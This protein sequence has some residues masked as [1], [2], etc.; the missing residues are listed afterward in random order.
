MED[1]LP[2]RVCFGGFEFDLKSGELRGGGQAVRLAEKPFRVLL[3]LVEHAG[4]LVT[5]EE[6]QKSL[7]PNDTIVDFEHGINTA[8]KVL[9]RALGDPAEHPRFIETLP[10]R[11]YRLLVPV[12]R[13]AANAAPLNV[14]ARPQPPGLIGKKVS[15][16]RVLDIIG[17]GG[18]GVVYRA[19]DLKLGRAVALKFLPE[20]VANDALALQRFERE[21]RTASSLN[22]PNICTIHEVEEHDGQPFLVMELLQGET[23]RDR[24][25][26]L[27]ASAK[28]IPVEQLLDIAL[29]VAD[30]LQAAH[31]KGIIHRDI[32]PANIFL[33]TQGQIKILDFGLAKLVERPGSSQVKADPAEPPFELSSRAEAASFA[34]GVERSA[35]RDADAL[36]G[37]GFNRADEASISPMHG[38]QHSELMPAHDHEKDGHN[39]TP[40]GVP[41]QSPLD[42]TLTRTGAA[43]GTAGYMS[44]EQVRGEKLDART[45][46][47]SFGLVLYE[48]ATGRRAFSGGTAAVVRDAILSSPPAPP[49]ELNPAVPAKLEA[50]INKSLEK[51]RDRR[52]Q[53]ASEIGAAL[54][55][56]KQPTPRRSR[57]SVWAV[58]GFAVVLA[59][60]A[61]FLFLRFNSKTSAPSKNLVVRQL[62]PHSQDSVALN[63]IALSPDGKRLAYT[64]GVTGISLLQ[65]DSGETRS[66]ANTAS[67]VPVEWLP[68]GDH[69]FLTKV[70]EPGIFKMSILDG[71]VRNFSAEPIFPLTSPD[72]QQIA[73]AKNNDEIWVMSAAGDS[74]RK[75]ISIPPPWVGKH[76]AWSPTGK[77]IAY[78]K[79][80]AIQ[81]DA[82]KQPDTTMQIVIDTC[83]L[84]GNCSEAFSDPRLHLEITYSSIA[85][86]PDGRMIFSLRESPPNER[87]SN[88]WSLQVDPDSGRALGQPVRL[89]N[90]TGSAQEDMV[91]SADG[92][93]LA[94]QQVNVETAVKVAALRSDA[95]QLETGRALNSDTWSGRVTGWTPDGQT[96]TFTAVR[97]GKKGIFRQGLN[98]RTPQALVA[99]THNYDTPVLSPDGQWL[100]Y[101][102]HL[103]DGSARLM[104]MLLKGGPATEVM[105]GDYG[106]RCSSSAANICIISEMRG[107]QVVF[108]EFDPFKGR[109]RDLIAADVKRSYHGF[110][111][112][113]SLSPDGKLIALADTGSRDN[114][115]VF[116]IADGGVKT[117]HLDSW[118]LLQS[119]SW[120]ADGEHLYLSGAR[121][122][123]GAFESWAI[124]ELDLT[125]NFKVLL[126]MPGSRGWF[127]SPIPSP[128]GRSL[129]YTE[130]TWPLSV[131]LL[132]NF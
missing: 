49:H 33:T 25:A 4:E 28:L 27:T 72:G 121:S 80:K 83:D 1:T 29:Q 10:R 124:L 64:D 103:D 14:P 98:D 87:S 122:I 41:F 132:E 46:L 51:D 38:H 99:G 73:Y 39:G 66:F 104:R 30:G 82:S 100:L 113:W 89:T 109:G 84:Q 81:G 7:W 32:K 55:G 21:A 102:E 58:A 9:R 112:A 93:R 128:D 78:D 119:V 108:S 12:E 60:I 42:P 92:K 34:A 75:I 8:I 79:V 19:E 22:H 110:G 50:V 52:Y 18:M 20:E 5:R 114:A 117:L 111:Y 43:M 125:G 57:V 129:V 13:K 106:Y 44:P 97:Y 2:D 91:A 11:G 86:L 127:Y 56:M 105:P 26:T 59:A 118:T 68:D 17:G 62:T 53:S 36:K 116:N 76:Y 61:G 65:V 48:M 101:T 47:F 40:E 31:Q 16:Y 120:S 115:R 130:R 94:F 96:V 45:D 107:A 67:F 123:S 54:R 23:L 131:V 71:T 77:R 35:V 70:G 24:L 95:G 37:H 85:W 88:L 6:M 3:L 126:T 90:W 15:H 74:P 69:L 63:S